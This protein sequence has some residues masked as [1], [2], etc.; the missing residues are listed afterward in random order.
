MAKLHFRY[1]TVA[2]GKTLDLL[3]VAYNYEENNMFCVILTS[4]IDDRYGKDV[5]KSRTGLSKPATGVSEKTNIY[6]L[7][8]N[9]NRKIDCIL[10]DEIQFFTKEHVYQLGKIVDELNIPVICYGLRSD[11][12]HQP[13]GC[14]SNL[15]AIA[16]VL[17]EIKTI[18]SN[19]GKKKSSVNG[20]FIDGKLVDSGVQ[21]EI[22]GNEKYK[23][24]CRKCYTKLLD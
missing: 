13:F 9:I 11:F 4:A 18:C 22:G 10:V 6:N 12:M 3:K 20:K 17:E 8:T 5:V 21:V 1:G 19:C 15:M 2:S 24:L 16:D 14:S 7:I 23:P